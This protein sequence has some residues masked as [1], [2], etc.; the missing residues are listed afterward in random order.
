MISFAV[1]I[2]VFG[3]A[4]TL[5]LAFPAAA[6]RASGP[7]CDEP[8]TQAEINACAY[9][10]LQEADAELNDEWKSLR[11]RLRKA[12]E[13]LGYEGW[14][15]TALEGQR[16]WLAY[17]DGQCAAEGY[18]MGGGTMEGM[19]VAYCKARLTRARIRELRELDDSG[20]L[21][22]GF[23]AAGVLTV[24]NLE[25]THRNGTLYRFPRIGGDTPAAVRINTYLQTRFLEQIPGHQRGGLF[26]RV[27]PEEGS[28]HGLVGL[29]YTL[30]FEQPGILRVDV[31]SE[32]YGAGYTESLD[33]VHFDAGTGQRITLRQLL[34]PEGLAQVD[35]EIRGQRLRK[36][37]DFLAGKE[38]GGARLRSDPEEAG[39][40]K[41][42]YE[43]CRAQVEKSHPA[44]G[45][46]LRI[47]QQSYRLV[48]EP[49]GSR[50]SWA[51]LDLE[52][53]SVR[54]F[55]PDRE[56]L[57]EYGRC[58]LIDRRASC[59]RGEGG[60]A[61]GVYLGKIADH[62]PVTLVVE[63]VSWEGV[64]NA[65]F[66]HAERG[67]RIPLKASLDEEGDGI[68]LEADAAGEVFRLR[69]T[70]SG[71]WVGEWAQEGKEPRLVSLR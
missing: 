49:C 69:P 17:R 71:G 58:L 8:Q 48:N 46:E 36:I 7:D 62:G 35:A 66:F 39:E 4:L 65:W 14:F 33:T 21:P 67:E 11:T 59:P 29:D 52:L 25:A 10:A 61:P 51:L 19:E 31:Y 45:D 9:E 53:S 64:P 60:P 26:A 44:V 18:E 27:W 43:E 5:T 24:E 56:T 54:G 30:A 47:D 70:P 37:D 20:G 1:W 2:A 40:Q 41:F 63:G 22:S 68:L 6:A 23:P 13:D 50:A 38:V 15:D 3:H 32:F 12:E 42:L 34:T 16:G 28:D 55:T 57:S